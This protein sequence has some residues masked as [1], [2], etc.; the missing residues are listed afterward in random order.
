MLDVNL[1]VFL[2]LK[3]EFG[4]CTYDLL[5]DFNRIDFF[6]KKL[7]FGFNLLSIELSTE[8]IPFGILIHE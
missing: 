5:F 6:L 2:I 1:Y 7:K 8:N 3:Y 4:N